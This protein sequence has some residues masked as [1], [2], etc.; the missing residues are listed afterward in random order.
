MYKSRSPSNQLASSFFV[1]DGSEPTL[2]GDETP[3]L[4]SPQYRNTYYPVTNQ[5]PDLNIGPRDSGDFCSGYCICHFQVFNLWTQTLLF[6]F[7]RF[8]FL[9]HGQDCIVI[10]WLLSGLSICSG[11]IVNC[12]Q[13]NSR[14]LKKSLM[15]KDKGQISR[16]TVTVIW[17]EID[18]EMHQRVEI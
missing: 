13:P 3:V 12:V 14:Q 5:R 1:H 4:Q 16:L 9:C 8:F 11:I 6:I 10:E 18:Y 2:S 15:I 7:L 17:S